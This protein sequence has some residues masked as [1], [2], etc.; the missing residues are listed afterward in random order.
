VGIRAVP[1]VEAMLAL[2]LLDHYLLHRAQCG[3]V[4]AQTPR[5]E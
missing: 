2:V 5:I 1:I 4:P 3:D